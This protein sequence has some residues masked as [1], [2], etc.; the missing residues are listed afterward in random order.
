MANFSFN[1]G[2]HTLTQGAARAPTRMHPRSASPALACLDHSTCAKANSW[3]HMGILHVAKRPNEACC[4]DL[5]EAKPGN[6]AVAR[7]KLVAGMS[8]ASPA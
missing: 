6:Q 3:M 1:A 5:A 4:V 7:S 8:Q 2:R